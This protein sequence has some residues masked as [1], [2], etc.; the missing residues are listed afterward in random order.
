MTDQTLD[1]DVR[2][3]GFR[4]RASVEEAWNW[5][6]YHF[7]Q[8][9]RR[10]VDVPLENSYGL[11]LAET[12]TSHINVPAFDRSAMDGYAVIAEETTGATD[13]QPISLRIIGKSLP[14]NGFSGEIHAGEAVEIM[15]GAPIPAGA[16]AVVP[17]E[18]TKRDNDRVDLTEPV[19]PLKHIGRVG[20][21]IAVGDAVVEKLRILRPQDVAVLASVG[22]TGVKVFALP[23]V[24]VIITGNEL[25][26]PGEE[27]KPHQIF[28]ANSFLLRGT[29]ARDGGII[30]S[31][32]FIRDDPSAI[33]AALLD[34][35]ADVILISGGS[36]V[37][38]EDH[39][40]SLIRKH[41]ELQIHG[42]RMRPSS[43]AGMGKVGQTPVFLLPGNPV[44][45]LC[46]YD[47]FASRYIRKVRGDQRDWP[48]T[49]KQLVLEK[50]ISSAIGRTD[51]CRVKVSKDKAVP[52]GVSGAGILSSTTRADG[53]VIVP[54]MSEGLPAGSNVTVMLYDDFLAPL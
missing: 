35:G 14:G 1:S 34:E 19:S 39:A 28:E 27:R 17:V 22:V 31:I 32:R 41:G 2:M 40:P 45:C 50:K 24:R 52:L 30:E 11:T 44:S 20:E 42:I 26:K 38:A 7:A 29:I 53:F 13:Y 46:A 21:D 25:V 49:S 33:E 3:S 4:Q 12:I 54:E 43:P 16:N 10:C 18:F 6:E 37:G 9:G 23:R 8:S 51:Y 48:F 15:T 5:I 47:F 36:S